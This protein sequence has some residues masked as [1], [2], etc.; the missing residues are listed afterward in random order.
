MFSPRELG[1]ERGWPGRIDGERVV[2]LAA[3]TLQSFFTGGGEARE[4]ADSAL[5]DVV[6]RAPVLHPPSVRIFGRDG[7]FVF[8]NPAAIHGPDDVVHVPQGASGIV[9]VLRLAAIVGAEQEIGGY[10]LM[11]DWDAPELS[12]TKAVDFAISLG[13]IVVTPDELQLPDVDFDALVAHAAANTRL[14]PGDVITAPGGSRKEMLSPGDTGEVS[15]APFGALRN[16][17]VQLGAATS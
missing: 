8:A 6:L 17:L 9:P 4:H 16:R 3:Q 10:T 11:N 12:G 7:D 1:L 14:L 2:Q 13:P 5:G 15:M